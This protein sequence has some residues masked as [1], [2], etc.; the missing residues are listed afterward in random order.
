VTPKPKPKP[1]PSSVDRG[2]LGKAQHERGA[3][4]DLHLRGV[5]RSVFE[6]P[7]KSELDGHARQLDLDR[8]R[9]AK[10]DVNPRCLIAGGLVRWAEAA[11]RQPGVKLRVAHR[12]LIEEN[13]LTRF[14]MR[15]FQDQ[16]GREALSDQAGKGEVQAARMALLECECLA[17]R[18]Q[19]KDT[20]A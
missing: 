14:V 8:C 12:Q 17:V 15:A 19:P 4:T 13:S 6:R 20:V 3:L 11:R 7:R 1:K 9:P 16:T 5:R 10:R 2:W 18:G